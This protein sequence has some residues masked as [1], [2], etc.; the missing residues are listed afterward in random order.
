MAKSKI[1]D[2]KI[3]YLSTCDTCRRVIK[4]LDL[5]DGFL[6]QNIK[7]D[8]INLSQIEDLRKLAGSYE[9]IFNK[10]AQLYRKRDL[11]NKNL[12][13]ED[14]KNLLLEHYTFL[15]R[16][17]LILNDKLFLGGSKKVVEAAKLEL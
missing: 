9:A 3:Y 1:M 2:N 13:E 17:A 11:K 7:T 12:Q 10:R 4:E 5:P 6:K 8:P 15:K 14:Y 16:P